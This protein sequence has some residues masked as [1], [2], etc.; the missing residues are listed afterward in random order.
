M[1]ARVRSV[2]EFADGLQHLSIEVPNRE[3]QLKA[4][5]LKYLHEALDED[6]DGFLSARDFKKHFGTPK[7]V[8]QCTTAVAAHPVNIDLCGIFIL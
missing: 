2:E 4:D 8:R 3:G 5:I 1:C 6:K 7:Q